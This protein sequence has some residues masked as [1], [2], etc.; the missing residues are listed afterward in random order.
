MMVRALTRDTDGRSLAPV[1][2]VHL[3]L[4]N[5]FR[6][7]QAWYTD[8]SSDAGEW[9]IAAFSGRS[10]G[11]TEALRDQD[12]LYMLVTRGPLGNQHQVISSLSDAR[13]GTDVAAL[14]GYLASAHVGILTTTITEAGYCRAPGGGIDASSAAVAA[15][16]AALRRGEVAALATAPGKIVAGL[17]ERRRNDAGPISLVPCDNLPHN[18][19]ALRDVVVDLAGRVD[20]SLLPWLESSVS[21]VTTMVDR[22]TPRPTPEAVQELAA[23][24]SITDPTAVVTEPFAEWVLSG[25]FG[26][27]RPAWESAGAQFVEDVAP[28][29][30]RKLWLLNGSH[31][32]MAYAATIRGH[33]TVCDAINDPVVLSWVNEWW[34]V[35]VRHLSLQ[36]PTVA[37]YR[38]AL[39]ERYRNPNIRHLLAQIASDGSVKLPIRILPAL[40]ADLDAGAEPVGAERAVAA[41]ILHLRG[42]GAPLNDVGSDPWRVAAAGPLREAVDRVCESLGIFDT[43]SRGRILALAS[44][45]G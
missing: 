26:G 35:A 42:L 32:L 30:Q 34:D 21:F 15:D 6:A 13:P 43:C 8:Q 2:A 3:G 28:F 20:T 4:G 24:S 33:D 14:V 25:S 19:A 10:A 12:F 16:L 37:A 17:R 22:I 23:V 9:G 38:E 36:G 27:A 7:H 39:I 40:L 31:S 44:E 45:L 41:W 5:F 18:A 29:E 11:V 1:R